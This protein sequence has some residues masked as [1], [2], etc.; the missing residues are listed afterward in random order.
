MSIN[1]AV[2]WIIDSYCGWNMRKSL[3]HTK[4]IWCRPKVSLSVIF[5]FSPHK[6]LN[7]N[8]HNSY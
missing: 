1:T 6:Q 2:V 7:K 3:S 4:T 8:T 5:V